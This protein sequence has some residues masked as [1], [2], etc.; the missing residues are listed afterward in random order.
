MRQAS[1][2]IIAVSFSLGVMLVACGEKQSPEEQVRHFIETGKAA[3]EERDVIA[4][5]QLVSEH[6][7]DS[8]Q[9]DRRALVGLTTGY[10]LRKKNIHLFTKIGK[11]TFPAKEKANV[12]LYAAMVGTPVTGA[13]ALIDLRADIYQFDLSLTKDDGDWLLIGADWQQA[14]MDDLFAGE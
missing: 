1:L 11:I 12:I 9:R 5:S 13:Q 4:F 3:V 8:S 7:R 2:S 14:S 10:F 6:Y